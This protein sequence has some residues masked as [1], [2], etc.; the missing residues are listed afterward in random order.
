MIAQASSSSTIAIEEHLHTRQGN[1]IITP[2]ALR[3]TGMD[4]PGGYSNIG[5]IC[6]MEAI[7]T[8]FLIIAVNVG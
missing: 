2:F 4:V 8:G 1:P 7:G 3:K 5:K 6:L